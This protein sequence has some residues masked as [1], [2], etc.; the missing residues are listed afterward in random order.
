METVFTIEGAD[1]ATFANTLAGIVNFVG[2][3]WRPYQ[4]G[5]LWLEAA[6]PNDDVA[7]G[8]VAEAVLPVRGVYQQRGVTDHDYRAAHSQHLVTFTV[9]SQ[10]GKLVVTAACNDPT[11]AYVYE[12]ILTELHHDYPQADIPLKPK[13]GRPAGPDENN[14]ERDADI[15]RLYNNGHGLSH[16]GL[17]DRF[18]L[19][20]ARIKQILRQQREL[21]DSQSC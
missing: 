20:K 15:Y 9:T 1:I 19:S 5:S 12:D 18:N 14:A 7:E 21:R 2:N 17:V 4:R 13:G 10:P 16:A 8:R 11:L 3:R 6:F